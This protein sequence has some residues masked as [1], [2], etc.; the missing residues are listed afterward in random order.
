MLKKFVDDK[1][2]VYPTLKTAP[3][4]D[5]TPAF[6]AD[7]SWLAQ[8]V[9][10]VGLEAKAAT[11]KQ[12]NRSVWEGADVE[13]VA[14][15][16]AGVYCLLHMQVGR[17]R[18][19]RYVISDGNVWCDVRGN[20]KGTH[21]RTRQWCEQK[22]PWKLIESPKARPLNKTAQ[23]VIQEALKAFYAVTFKA[24]FGV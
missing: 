7:N 11:K 24:K 23:A 13:S 14:R 5:L 3:V 10:L 2:E 22:G 18:R 9:E 16:E 12:W 21:Y 4:G 6:A 19:H 15:P 20:I 1:I 17:G 8:G